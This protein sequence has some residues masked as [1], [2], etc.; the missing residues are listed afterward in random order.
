MFAFIFIYLLRVELGIACDVYKSFTVFLL[1]CWTNKYRFAL[2]Y[3]FISE[4]RWT[5]E[6]KL[7]IV[8]SSFNKL[9]HTNAEVYML[10]RRAHKCS[11]RSFWREH[12]LSWRRRSKWL[13]THS[14]LPSAIRC[15]AWLVEVLSPKSVLAANGPSS[16]TIML[17]IMMQAVIISVKRLRSQPYAGPRSTAH[18]AWR[19]P[20]AR[21]ILKLVKVSYM[22]MVF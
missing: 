22:E 6:W 16:S 8:E 11:T 7:H 18:L 5:C 10:P 13:I 3:Y 14:A 19:T 20:N 2:K 15:G 21:S 17:C 12:D 9:E 4:I 1:F